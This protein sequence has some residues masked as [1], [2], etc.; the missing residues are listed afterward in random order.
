MNLER[1]QTLPLRLW[2][3]FK[4]QLVQDV[5]EADAVCEF[6]C[7]K[8]HCKHGEWASCERRIRGAAGELWP[9]SPT[10]LH[11]EGNSG[12]NSPLSA[13]RSPDTKE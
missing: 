1:I 5:P 12:T 3:W 2:H 4:D 13:A 6:D 7:R 10:R 9:E 11:D 8:P